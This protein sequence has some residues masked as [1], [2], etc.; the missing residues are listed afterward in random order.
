[1]PSKRPQTP[2]LL[3]RTWQAVLGRLELEVNRANFE[4]WLV[5]TVAHSL[6]DG[7]LLVE[8]R[9]AFRADWLNENLVPTVERCLGAIE[10]E[11]LSVR[12]VAQGAALVEKPTSL[13][14]EK[15]IGEDPLHVLGQVNRSFTFARYF[16]SQ[17]SG[18]ALAS[19]LGLLDKEEPAISPVVVYGPPGMGK[20]HL[21]HAL[22][23][24]AH[25]EGRRVACLSGEEFTTR[26]QRALRGGTIEAFQDS[27]R[28]VQLLIVDDLQ[29]LVGKTGTLRELTHTLD[30]VTHAGG[31]AAL[32][33]ELHPR[34]LGLPER[35]CSRLEAGIVAR[36][37]P[38]AVTERRAFV[39]QH[40]AELRIG[41]P[42]WCLEQL[43]SVTGSV[44]A[45]LAGVHAAVGLQ[46]QGLLNEMS[47]GTELGA[48]LLQS[49]EKETVK[50]IIERIA[51]HFAIETSEVAGRSR[52]AKQTRARAVVVAALQKRGNSYGEIG[53]YLGG[54]SRSTIKGLAERGWTLGKNDPA[55]ATLLQAV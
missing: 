28:G 39:N 44:R 37:D 51:T 19:C 42:A 52:A 12:F 46:K 53:S 3:E 10:G 4:T 5:G 34:Q 26:Y 13:I 20:T 45:I 40:L 7:E 22:A 17:G 8:A 30:A 49:E 32:G 35:L 11:Q 48:L 36:V 1:V 24:K 41:L 47:L 15:N 29:D 54:R 21:L 31:A 2:R 23:A 50:A 38:F 9:S 33:S 16:R 55:I 6:H 14:V 18:L 43:A 27:V 25:T